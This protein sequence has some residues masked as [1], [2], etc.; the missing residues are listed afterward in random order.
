MKSVLIRAYGSN[1]QVEFA[2]VA[3]PVPEA[4][5]IL[6]KVDAAGVNPIDWKIRGGAGQRMGMT[7]P[8]RL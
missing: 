1:D 3:R 5:E 6:I 4:G 2:E 8:I 7:L